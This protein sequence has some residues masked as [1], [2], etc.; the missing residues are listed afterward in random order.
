M[1]SLSNLLPSLDIIPKGGTAA[2]QRCFLTLSCKRLK[3]PKQRETSSLFLPP[4]RS[5]QGGA[6]QQP[7]KD[8]L[9]RGLFMKIILFCLTHLIAWGIRLSL[10]RQDL[11]LVKW[12]Q[13]HGRT[14][15]ILGAI[16]FGAFCYVQINRYQP[17]VYRYGSIEQSRLLDRWTGETV[18]VS[19]Y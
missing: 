10:K 6:H 2:F 9:D 7:S 8:R 14:A 3:N 17:F 16:L 13:S 11:P 1:S 18:Q 4:M 5:P 12:T 15:A 19:R